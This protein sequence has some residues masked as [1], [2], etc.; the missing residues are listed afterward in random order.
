[1]HRGGC[2]VWGAARR[3]SVGPDL[4]GV[5]TPVSIDATGKPGGQ[6]G[7]GRRARAALT[8]LQGRSRPRRKRSMACDS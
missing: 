7:G 2:M 4:R 6:L 3:V 8:R 5:E 1:M